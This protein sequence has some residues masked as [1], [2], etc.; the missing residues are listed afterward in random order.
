MTGPTHTS[1]HILDLVITPGESAFLHSVCTSSYISDH[2][3][4]HCD[5]DIQKQ[6]PASRIATFRRYNKINN[7]FFR[8]DLAACFLDTSSDLDGLIDQFTSSITGIINKHAPLTTRKIPI[9]QSIPWYSIDSKLAKQERR[10]AE[11]RWSLT[12]LTIH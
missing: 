3:A 9:R 5:L 4:I 10:K 8:E 12:G 1:G 7:I 11:R 6:P 2:A